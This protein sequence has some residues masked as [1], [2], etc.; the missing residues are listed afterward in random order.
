M[1]DTNVE[2]WMARDIISADPHMRLH[3]ALRLVNKNQIRS[4]PVMEDG[5][6]VG[7]VTKRDLLRADTTTVM[8]DVW[9]QYRIVGNLP[10]SNIMSRA[11]ITINE[12]ADIK[13]A[14]RVLQENKIT[15]LPVVNADLKMVGI[16]TS[17]DIFRFII[18]DVEEQASP[19]LVRSYMTSKV[20][21]IDPDTDIMAAH[22]LMAVNHFRA[23]PVMQTG[24]LVG[25]ITRTDLL[26][27]APSVATTQGHQDISLQI[28]STPVRYLMTSSPLTIGEDQTLAE[29]AQAMFENKIHSLP[30]FNREHNLSGII[31]E[32]DLFRSVEERI[33]A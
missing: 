8:K 6:L 31:T 23:L 24:F 32:T 15:C 16:L 26:S 14:T 4:L 18:A 29:A 33:L 10:L 25:I 20:V 27:A 30:V 11:V 13:A 9:D 28:Y 22:R 21:T 7:I 5:E 12:K 1:K 19:A 3:D 17:S 2:Q